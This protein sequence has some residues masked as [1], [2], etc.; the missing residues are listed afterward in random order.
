[1]RKGEKVPKVTSSSAKCSQVTTSFGKKKWVLLMHLLKVPHGVSS[2]V[3]IGEALAKV[4]L[5]KIPELLVSFWGSSSN[6][7]I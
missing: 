7:V 6:L 1:L 5:K 2:F 3:D 4:G